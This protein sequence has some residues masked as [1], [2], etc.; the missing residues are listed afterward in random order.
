MPE[1]EQ[2]LT[3]ATGGTDVNVSFTPHLMPMSRGMQSTIYCKLDG[4]A[5]TEQ[6]RHALQQTYTT[7]PFVVVL[8]EG[9]VPATRHVRGSNYCVVGVFPDRLPGR[10]IIV[11]VIDNLVKGASGS[12]R[13]RRFCFVYKPQA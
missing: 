12:R 4:D 9:E 11:S 7:D 1:I 2:G 8:D 13:M 10:V 3:E 5:T 6:V